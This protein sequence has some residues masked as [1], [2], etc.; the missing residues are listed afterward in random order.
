MSEMDYKRLMSLASAE[1]QKLKAQLGALE[2]DQQEPIA[3]LGMSCRFPGDVKNPRMFWDLLRNGVDGVI[4]VTNQRGWSMDDFYDPD[5]AVKGK[6]NTR[7]QGLVS[8]VDLFD[9]EFFGIAPKE[10]ERLDPQQRLLLEVT[11]ETLEMAGYAPDKLG[12]SN[13][14]VFLG[15]SFAD[16]ATLQVA[17]GG[18][19]EMSA[20]DGTGNALS[21]AAGRL[22]YFFGL[23]GPCMSV[24]TACSSSL[25]A[26]SRAVQSLRTRECDTALSG[27]VS[28]ILSPM[29]SIIFSTARMLSTD[30]RCKTFDA[31][32]NGYVRGE[33]VGMIYLKRLSDA[34]RD[35]DN[36]LAL[37]RGVATNQD[38]RSQGLTAP[39]E[40]AQEA[41]IRKALENGGIHPHEVTYV[42]AHG[43]GTSLGD[44]IE[45]Q[46]IGAAYCE[47]RG[48]E[49]PLWVGSAK[50]NLGHMETAAGVGG[51]IKTVL[52]LQH[53]QIPPHLHFKTP[54]PYIAWDKWP[55]KIPTALES[56][57]GAD[58]DAVDCANAGVN[59]VERVRLGA[60]S[61]FGF[62]G[63]NAH[64]VLEQA[65]PVRAREAFTERP[66]HVLTLSARN[67]KA[68]KELAGKYAQFIEDSVS[69][70]RA[71][72]LGDI[73]YTANS[74]RGSFDMRVALT[75]H[76]R[77]AAVQALRALETQGMAFTH[78]G[79]CIAEAE[80]ATLKAGWLINGEGVPS[81]MLELHCVAYRNA[82]QQVTTALQ[83]HLALADHKPGEAALPTRS[84]VWAD[85]SAE[86]AD[87]L[88]FAHGWALAETWRSLG[89]KS[90]RMVG[91][92]SGEYIVAVQ[93]GVMSLNDAARLVCARHQVLTGAGR[94]L[95]SQ[96]LADVSLQR[97]RTSVI[98]GLSGQASRDEMVAPAY[99]LKHLDATADVQTAF[100][101]LQNSGINVFLEI[102]TGTS[103]LSQGGARLEGQVAIA[104]APEG[105]ESLSALL[106]AA[107]RLWCAGIDIDWKSLEQGYDRRKLDL[108]TYPF[109]RKRFW[110]KNA[111]APSEGMAA[112]KFAAF[113][114]PG[115]GGAPRR[116]A[117]SNWYYELNWKPAELHATQPLP[118]QIVVLLDQN[119]SLL[120][121]VDALR[122][123]GVV[124]TTAVQG[125]QFNVNGSMLSFDRRD[126]AQWVQ[127]WGHLRTLSVATDHVVWGGALDAMTSAPNAADLE[128]TLHETL[129][130]AQS[131]ALAGML[132]TPRLWLITRNAVGLDLP[133][134]RIALSQS[135]L[136]GMARVFAYE[137]MDA[138]VS[139]VDLDDATPATVLAGEFQQAEF[140]DQLLY[141]QGDRRV[142]RLQSLSLDDA[143]VAKPLPVSGEK[144][145][146]ITGGLGGLGILFA[147]WLAGQGARHLVL[148]GRSVPGEAAQK[149]LT[150]LRADGVDVQVVAADVSL[151]ADVSR[152]FAQ[153]RSLPALGGVL[154]AAG[155]LDDGVLTQQNWSRFLKVLAPKVNAG[156]YLHEA[157]A[158]LPALDFFVMFSSIA[159]TL[160][161]PGQSNY[162]AANAFLDALAVK[163][164][165]LGLPAQVINWGPWSGAGMASADKV[166]ARLEKNSGFGTITETAG[167]QS[168]NEL[169]RAAPVQAAVVPIDWSQVQLAAGLM[170]ITPPVFLD[171]LRSRADGSLGLA[172]SAGAELLEQLQV[173]RPNERHKLAIDFLRDKVQQV[174]GL[175]SRPDIRLPMQEL[176]MDSL[177]AVEL[178]NAISH[179]MGRAIPVAVM[180]DFPTIQKLA[181]YLAEQLAEQVDASAAMDGETASTDATGVTAEAETPVVAGPSAQDVLARVMASSGAAQLF[182][183]PA[184]VAI[185]TATPASASASHATLLTTAINAPTEMSTD[186]NPMSNAVSPEQMAAALGWIP[187]SGTPEPIAVIGMA[188][189]FPGGAADPA[190]FWKVLSEGIDGVV[191]LGTK[192]W[193]MEQF[194]D[195][196]PQVGGKMYIRHG[197]LIDN[198]DQFDADFFSISPREATAMDPQQRL[199]LETSWHA[200]ESAGYTPDE[201]AAS[202][203][204]V[205]VGIAPNDYSQQMYIHIDPK[206]INAHL[207]TGAHASM[208][209]G[210]LSYF[211][212]WQGP[213]MTIDTAC[214]SSLVAIHNASQALRAG[215][216]DAAIAGGSNLTLSPLLNVTL[217]RAQMLAPDGHCKSFDANA[218]GYVRSEG[219]GIVVLKRLSVALQDGDNIVALIRGSA[220]NQDGRSQGITAPNG[221]AQEAV[222]QRALKNAGVTPAQVDYV[223]AHGTGTRLGDPIEVLALNNTYG[224]AHEPSQPLVIGAVKS[225]IGHCEA[226]AGVAGVIK[227]ILAMQHGQIPAN[228]N[229]NTISPY[230]QYD[231]ARMQFA[232]TATPWPQQAGKPKMAAVSS[233]G[234][235]GSNSHAILQEAP[236]RSVRVNV[237][238]RPQHLLT[239]SGRSPEARSALIAAYLDFLPQSRESLGDIAFTASVGRVHH[240]CRA[241]VVASSLEDLKKKLSL[242]AEGKTQVGIAQGQAND[243]DVAFLFPG[244]GSQYPGMARALYEH[245]PAFRRELDACRDVLNPLLP[246]DLYA[247]LWGEHSHLLNQTQFTQP[248]LF[249]LEVALANLLRSWGVTPRVVMGHS[250]GEY[251][252]AYTAGVF[253]LEDGARLIAARGRLM[254]ALPAGGKMCA[255]GAPA[256]MVEPLVA[257]YAGRVSVAAYN[258]PTQTVISGVGEVVDALMRQFAGQGVEVNPLDVSHAFHSPLMQPMLAEFA[259]VATSIRYRKPMMDVVSNLTGQPER[260]R[261]CAP[262]YWIE[263]V[264]APVRFAEGI[265]RMAGLNPGAMLEVG[266][267]PVLLGMAR[268]TL[269]K[270]VPMIPCLRAGQDDWRLLL[271]AMGELYCLGAEIDWRVLD[272]DYKRQRVQVPVYPFQGKRHWFE[273][274]GDGARALLGANFAAKFGDSMKSSAFPLLGERLHL[275]GSDEIRFETRYSE[276]RPGYLVDHKLFGTVVVPGASHVSLFLSA[277]TQVLGN[278]R[279]QLTDTCFLQPIVLPDGGKRIVQAVL[280]KKGANQYQAD[281]LSIGA[282]QDPMD[283]SLWITHATT[284]IEAVPVKEVA[285]IPVDVTDVVATWENGITGADFYKQFNDQGY[286]L[287]ESFQWLA[288]A[289]QR[290]GIQ[291]AVWQMR[292][293]TLP[294]TATDYR[295]YPSLIDACFQSLAGC[296]VEG[297]ERNT[298]DEIYIPFSVADLRLVRTP[299]PGDALWVYASLRPREGDDRRST[300][301]D[302]L[303]FDGEGRM[304]AELIGVESRLAS[305]SALSSNLRKDL[306]N[307]CMYEL[308]W[309]PQQ[310]ENAGPLDEGQWLILMDSRGVGEALAEQLEEQGRSVQRVSVDTFLV[311]I[312]SAA[313]SDSLVDAGAFE[314]MLK[315]YFPTETGCAGIVHLWALN[316]YTDA[317]DWR[318]AQTLITGSTLALMSALTRLA[319]RQTPRVWLATEAAQTPFAEGVVDPHQTAQWGLARVFAM[320]HAEFRTV[321]VDLDPTEPGS[322][323]AARVFAEL[324]ASGG[325]QREDQVM[326]RDGA[327]YVARLARSRA[328]RHPLTAA[329]ALTVKVPVGG[330]LDKLAPTPV[331]RREPGENEIEIEVRATSLNFRDVLN[332]LGMFREY[333]EQMGL[334]LS[335]FPL[336]FDCAGVVRKVGPGVTAFQPGDAV[337]AGAYNA[338]STHVVAHQGWVWK[339]PKQLSFEQAAAIPT[340]FM[341]A[342][343]ALA[344]LAKVKAGDKVLIHAAAGGVG[345][346]ALQVALNLGAEVYATASPGK[347]AYLLGKGVKAVFNSRVAD[348]ADGLLAVTGGHGVDVVL[349]SFNGD[350]IPE[351][352]KALHPD[353][354]FIEIGKIGVWSAAQMAEARSDVD[355][356]LFDVAEA[357]RTSGFIVYL[358]AFGE[359]MQRYERGELQALPVQV[360]GLDHLTDAFR[361]L[362]SGRNVGKVVVSMPLPVAENIAIAG[363]RSYLITGG[364]GSLGLRLAD[365][366]I[367]RGARDI[368]LTSRRAPADA[369][370]ARIEAMRARGANVDVACY[371]VADPQQARALMAHVKELHAPLA[372][373]VHAAGVLDDGMI[374]QQNWDRFQ[375]VYAPK[376]G[377]WT[378]HEET[379][380]LA[381]DFFCSFSSLASLLGSPSQSNYAAANAYLDGL[382]QLR[383]SQGLPAI[384]FNWGPWADGG[385]AANS[386]VENRFASGSGIGYLSSERGLLAFERWLPRQGQFGVMVMDWVK[387]AQSM[388]ANQLPALLSDV[389]SKVE[390]RDNAALLQIAEQFRAALFGCDPSERQGLMI[391]FICERIAS[392][393][394][395]DSG[396]VIDPRQP[397]QQ[398]GLDSL[399]AV[400]LRN[401]VNTMIGRSLPATL[402]F[403]YPSVSALTGYLVREIFPEHDQELAAELGTSQDVPV[404]AKP[405]PVRGRGGPASAVDEID[406]ASLSDED[407]A[408]LLAQS[409]D[410]LRETET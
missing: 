309:K 286:N 68:L 102:G 208:A 345:Q 240:A 56:W 69:D 390:S 346:A 196:D 278:D 333:A 323:S 301:G 316:G 369:V 332:A 254:Q 148:T 137:V 237:I 243:L 394:G 142:A 396:H 228:L 224:K 231:A 337:V 327:R 322:T 92:G 6:I 249:A 300:T 220:I 11:W 42:E 107:G 103:L 1:I 192:R 375:H 352:L 186:A 22:S 43:T 114:T 408:L 392:L 232:A 290:E 276:Q 119:E 223:E 207:G 326:Y 51:L 99:W 122:A 341:T 313:G 59:S 33:G 365:W 261:L 98:A 238:D 26:I 27:G 209:S 154:H 247:V 160:G 182:A 188:C 263:H 399:M 73:C 349:N 55:V 171:Q 138:K 246:Q 350:F 277:A 30:G 257:A 190:G 268:A 67:E 206:D 184:G 385:M 181:G 20:Y 104:T 205:Y 401:V 213:C 70:E 35:N 356:H 321:R 125:S 94:E 161:S 305:R 87:V 281:L 310:V 248:A 359:V 325:E 135:A 23:Q 96:A 45:M 113:R 299:Q 195:P 13:T 218:N 143:S 172:G 339:K 31:D 312:K 9:A 315:G 397:L 76:D 234:F 120:P 265:T 200:I 131:L 146:L 245:S 384:A 37:I 159:S 272:A 330:L 8:D 191:E 239:L 267:K 44:P 269:I 366:L 47:D 334:N 57:D 151:Q 284:T 199:L 264:F 288:N 382:T 62:G 53:A 121:L 388:G 86:W 7:A 169:L 230:L 112:D 395:Y 93:V 46:A 347:W 291:T 21:V 364:L 260:E 338:L 126:P 368:V 270:P 133:A 343:H 145:Y 100:V 155:V 212:G 318:A 287:G 115:E 71:T 214:S 311:G 15:A 175:D 66:M 82:L 58:R 328:A 193:D 127:F 139:R 52:C 303:L 19:D 280:R 297:N 134:E 235:S 258:T 279:V 380:D 54:S 40:I 61:S 225:N 63:S 106:L 227:T 95:F 262:D 357:T 204:G 158:A 123:T 36:I 198:V 403:K 373:V 273:E 219:C 389:A 176:G 355:Y 149:A 342:W 400:E 34:L 306:L 371:D 85:R 304:V 189:R 130:L 80:R 391:D 319:W 65:P 12:G 108:P 141:R 84:A 275:P 295:L 221:P 150:D 302:I 353:G 180:F 167:L 77:S 178:R 5:P 354:R 217:C 266:P 91:V 185:S 229:L 351:S 17:A 48:S 177:M 74:G 165:A 147:R 166:R 242:L 28:L 210:R 236:P 250:V 24:D 387:V 75:A 109:Q 361:H 407:A 201:L 32:A 405:K 203:P 88:G 194:Y 111:V 252:A 285:G 136:L 129:L 344:V 335:E 168:F 79:A 156:W 16:Y 381:L 314:G 18:M 4:D 362:Q 117:A 124:V 152:L 110:A 163:R 226:A 402:L 255:I 72:P 64:I 50:T 10:A 187:A 49:N 144:T 197:G 3:I 294:D 222:I 90:A 308:Q 101:T 340:V 256:E 128:T 289:W 183:A 379:R 39:N 25:I 307:D 367:E 81:P 320:E 2:R 383:R 132:K 174:M 324:S 292:W 386:T 360:F 393:L 140:E 215:E 162:A 83:E 211:L 78:S 374:L 317:A 233:F 298:G 370:A 329:Q 173:A 259:E 116:S 358:E 378:L 216:C 14:G 404:A 398:L 336:G 38:G 244:Q 406:I 363:D 105:A 97:A 348:F 410:S 60:V 41:V 164:R 118:K 251:A 179:A 170:G 376:F 282:D 331:E 372:G 241:A 271:G 29:N 274:S 296:D 283:A 293:P 89:V 253:S 153:M 202:T 409:L 377:A 157:T